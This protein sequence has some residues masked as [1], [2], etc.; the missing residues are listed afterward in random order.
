MGF[1]FSA[2]RNF[3]SKLG[4]LVPEDVQVQSFRVMLELFFLSRFDTSSP[5]KSADIGSKVRHLAGA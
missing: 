3:F 1:C 4:L 5:E 2:L